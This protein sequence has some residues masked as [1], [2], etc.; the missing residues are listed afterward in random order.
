MPLSEKVAGDL[1]LFVLV[2]CEIL[3][4]SCVKFIFVDIISQNGGV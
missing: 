2:N 3:D 4:D 1:L